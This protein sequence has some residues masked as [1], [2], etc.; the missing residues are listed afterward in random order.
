MM[1]DDFFVFINSCLS[2][3]AQKEA[4]MHEVRH[5]KLDHF[6]NQDPVVVN[7]MEAQL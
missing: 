1:Q 6:Y 5:I 3:E 7:E 4:T 2:P